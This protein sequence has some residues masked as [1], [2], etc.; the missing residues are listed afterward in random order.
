ML[1]N[2]DHARCGVRFP[3]FPGT[4]RLPGAPKPLSFHEALPPL[5]PTSLYRLLVDSGD[6][7]GMVFPLRGDRLTIG[8]GPNNGI[9]LVDSRISR[10][11]V[12][13]TL[14]R[15]GWWLEDLDSKNGTL[16]NSNP[17]LQPLSLHPGDIIH[18]GNIRL[19]YESE[20]A[21]PARRE[22][23]DD[24]TGVRVSA[25]ATALVSS[26]RLE[27]DPGGTTSILAIPEDA[28]GRLSSIYQIGQIIQTILDVDEMLGK[29]MQIVVRTLE[30]SHGAIFLRDSAAG[31]LVARTVY[32]AP[33][34]PGATMVS[35]SILEQAM[36]E[37]V[38]VIMSDAR[39]DR[40]FQDADSVVGSRIESA[41]CVPLIGK[42]EVLGAMYL[43]VRAAEGRHYVQKDLQWLVGVAGQAGL[44]IS[45][46]TLHRE[47]IE[48]RQRERD[49]EIA[50][51]IQMNLLPKSMPE[52]PGFEFA[53]IS[54]PAQMVGGDTYDVV[55]LP[56]GQPEGQPN[57]QPTGR[58]NIQVMLSIADVSG[59]GIPA[60]ILVASVR[61]AVRMEGRNLTREPVEE[62]VARLNAT[63][64]E[65]TM[66]NMFVTMVLGLLDATARR[67][68][69]CNAGHSH[70]ILRTP[71]GAISFLE[72]GGC[73]LGIDPALRI[74]AASVDLPPGSLLLLYTDGVT[75]A[76]NPAGE[77]FGLPRL[78]DFIDANMELPAPAF[79]DTLAS[80]VSTF[81][82][83]AEVFDDLTALVVKSL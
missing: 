17:V 58:P 48:K 15:H 73:F 76:L 40:R 36:D 41:M 35:K 54:R 66:S 18:I 1:R 8:R 61:S 43:D 53:G 55:L 10:E 24:S 29:L 77:A 9:Q 2:P 72:A 68:T 22:S 49:M 39:A 83:D 23:Q 4:A 71:D 26:H 12:R 28:E 69:F 46:A 51:S 81:A 80:A 7:R 25:E 33:D 56:A 38:G 62:V 32:R 75:D 82:G 42:G 44:A 30:P 78:L 34:A 52:V 45:I 60:A 67:F 70:P 47:A 3:R 57:A 11:H 20:L 16:V 65:E 64:C 5:T 79:I 37:R 14:R 19:I 63:V 50:R 13:L 21:Q 74:P 31:G 59:K 27:A 6:N